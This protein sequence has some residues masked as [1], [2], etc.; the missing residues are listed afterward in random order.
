MPQKVEGQ[1]SLMR[2]IRM[3]MGSEDGAPGLTLYEI[4]G[5]G[6]VHRQ[7]Q[8]HAH[9]SRFSPE[10]ILMRRPVNTDYM[11][12]H[13]AAEEIGSEDFELLWSE[14]HETRGFHKRIPDPSA[15]WDGTLCG[16]GDSRQLKWLPKGSPGPGWQVVPGFSRL[17]IYGSENDAWAAQSDLFLER[18]IEW[19]SALHLAA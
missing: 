9:G 4:D 15:S 10:D 11:A 19:H 8:I 17:F 18:S 16:I 5:K 13:P 12:L 14:V 6:W 7:V 3:Y 2:Y 1:L